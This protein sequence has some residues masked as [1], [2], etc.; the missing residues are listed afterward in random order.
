MA[1]LPVLDVPYMICRLFEVY[2]MTDLT[3]VV[4]WSALLGYRV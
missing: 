3:V 1:P 4:D 2:L